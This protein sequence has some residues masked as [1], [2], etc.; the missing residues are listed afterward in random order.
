M[1]ENTKETNKVTI[2]RDMIIGDIIQAKPEAINVLMMSGMGCIACPTSLYESLEEAC[3]V[4]GM[5]PDYMLDQLN[6][7]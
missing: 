5:D 7:L 3:M 4:H 2:T 6:S 1:T